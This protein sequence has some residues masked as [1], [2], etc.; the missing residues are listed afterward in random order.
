MLL[1]GSQLVGTPVLGLQTGARLAEISE[2][3]IDPANLKIVAYTLNGPLLSERPSMIMTSDIREHSSIGMIVDSSDE[4]IGLHDVVKIEEIVNLGFKLIGMNVIDQLKHKLGKV[5][6]YSV[7]SDGFV[8]EQL[9]VKR[10]V[11]QALTETSLLINRSQIVEINDHNIVVHTTAKK[12]E[13]AVKSDRSSFVNP[14][15]SSSPQP[16]N[17]DI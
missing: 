9:N 12:I 17:S 8:I 1:L 2:P 16:E 15:R 11:I 13:P 10:G 3:I 5:D 14:F 4:F 7:E 6:D